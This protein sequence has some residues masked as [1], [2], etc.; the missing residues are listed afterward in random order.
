VIKQGGYCKP[1]K[2]TY[3]RWNIRRRTML[4]QGFDISLS[5]LTRFVRKN[6]DG[7]CQICRKPWKNAR[8]QNL[9]HDHKTG[10]LRGLLCFLCNTGLGKLGD[11]VESLQRAIQ[12]LQKDAS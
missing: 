11:D 6:D 4:L 2:A 10:Q 1:C 5:E 8:D 9:D 3:M 7:H 12:Y